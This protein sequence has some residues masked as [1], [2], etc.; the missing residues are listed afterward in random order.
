MKISLKL[1]VFF[2]C[3]FTFRLDKVNEEASFFEIWDYVVDVNS[4]AAGGWL[5]TLVKVEYEDCL[6]LL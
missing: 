5:F 3:S 4:K 1:R 6:L 2:Y